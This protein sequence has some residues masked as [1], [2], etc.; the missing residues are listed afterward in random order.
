M[1]GETGP[2]SKENKGKK[3]SLFELTLPDLHVIF[4]INRK[5]GP[6]VELFRLHLSILQNILKKEKGGEERET[7]RERGKRGREREK[8]HSSQGDIPTI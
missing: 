7:E 4:T 5:T 2:E 3:G 1:S 6:Q 8:K